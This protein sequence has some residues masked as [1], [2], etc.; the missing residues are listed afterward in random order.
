[1]SVYPQGWP[2][3]PP[4]RAA[5]RPATWAPGPFH[6]GDAIAVFAYVV[7]F[8]FAGGYFLAVALGFIVGDP[9]ELNNQFMSNFVSYTLVTLIMTAVAWR[10]LM[11]SLGVFATGAWWKLLLLPG[12]WFANVVLNV[13][14]F[15]LLEQPDTSAN[16]AA[17]EAMSTAAPPL[18]MIIMTVLFAPL[19]EEYLF[20]HLLVGKLSRYLNVWVCGVVS[21]VLFASLHFMS[22]GFRFNPLEMVPYLTLATAITVSYILFHRSFAFAVILH[23]VNNAIALAVLYS[24]LSQLSGGG[25]ET[26]TLLTPWL[27]V[28]GW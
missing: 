26:A 23:M 7:V 1:M 27:H 12:I 24:P 14:I 3:R 22:T 6:F 18:L 15:T 4:M 28:L 20:R 19:V 21:I 17:L 9:M 25:A 16:Q 10:P 13:L 2:D 11:R 8:L 5:A